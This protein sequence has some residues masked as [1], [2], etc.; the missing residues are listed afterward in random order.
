MALILSK[1]DEQIVDVN[2]EFAWEKRTE[3]P[4]SLVRLSG[5]DHTQAVGDSVHMGVHAD[6]WDSKA[7]TKYEV[8]GLS[9]DSGKPE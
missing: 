5:H 2:P 9:S 8:C 3:F 6:R 7:E 1:R 4:L